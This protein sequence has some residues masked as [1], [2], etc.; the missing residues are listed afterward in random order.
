MLKE[1]YPAIAPLT[2]YPSDHASFVVVVYKGAV[3]FS[4][5]ELDLDLTNRAAAVL[6]FEHRHSVMLSVL[7]PFRSN[8]LARLT[9]AAQPIAPSSV[10]I[11]VLSEVSLTFSLILRSYVIGA[12]FRAMLH[13]GVMFWT[14]IE[15]CH[16][17]SPL[18]VVLPRTRINFQLASLV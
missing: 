8:D 13:E 10:R 15:G 3:A 5:V 7:P 17:S 18:I 2:K 9:P 16:S 14:V 6:L 1:A 4:L 12:A 11:E